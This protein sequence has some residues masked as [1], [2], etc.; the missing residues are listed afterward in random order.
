MAAFAVLA[1]GCGETVID[2]AKAEDAVQQSL[3][4]SLQGKVESVDCPAD[5]EVEKGRTFDCD[6]ILPEGQKAIATLRITS[7]DADVTI[8]GFKPIADGSE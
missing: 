1:S 7:D 6:V 5:E 4:K 3:E 2:Q 8:V